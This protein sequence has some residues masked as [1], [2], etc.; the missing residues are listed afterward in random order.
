MLQMG[1]VWGWGS[2]VWR[3]GDRVLGGGSNVWGLGSNVW[4]DGARMS[5][6]GSNVR[7]WGSNVVRCGFTFRRG[8]GL[9]ICRNPNVRRASNV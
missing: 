1:F 3:D 9:Y 2:N 5:G 8:W 4:R 6:G 7:G